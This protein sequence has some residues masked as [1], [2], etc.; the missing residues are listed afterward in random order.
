MNYYYKINRVDEK[1]KWI[2]IHHED[3]DKI[4]AFVNLLKSIENE[5][6]GK[7]VEVGDWQYK[8]EGSSFDLIYQWDDCFGSV[9]IYH[10]PA[11]K[12][13][14]IAFLQTHFDKLNV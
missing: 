4:D 1:E 13:P 10:R 5:C 12:E 2:F 7:V 6:S 14:A 11:Q 9:T 3:W 8:V